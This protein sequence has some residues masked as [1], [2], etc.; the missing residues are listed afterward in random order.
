MHR[1]IKDAQHYLA[2]AEVC[3]RMLD[4]VQAK[5]KIKLAR[6]SLDRCYEMYLDYMRI[7]GLPA[8]A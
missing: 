3:F 5:S 7:F 8:D 6:E 4:N 1:Q 2:E